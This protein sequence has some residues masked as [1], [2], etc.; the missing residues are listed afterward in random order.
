[1]GVFVSTSNGVKDLGGTNQGSPGGTGGVVRAKEA[2]MGDSGEGKF[3]IFTIFK[4]EKRIREK[5][6]D[7]P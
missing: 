6:E 5:D 4:E 2:T 7:E 3:P 1:M